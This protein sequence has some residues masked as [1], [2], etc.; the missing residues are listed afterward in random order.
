VKSVTATQPNSSS[1]CLDRR[2]K[3]DGLHRVREIRKP[4]Q[5]RKTLLKSARAPTRTMKSRLATRVAK[6]TWALESLARKTSVARSPQTM[7][8]WAVRSRGAGQ[9]NRRVSLR[10][11]GGGNNRQ[12][13]KCCPSQQSPLDCFIRSSVPPSLIRRNTSLDGRN[14]RGEGSSGEQIISIVQDQISQQFCPY[15]E[16]SV[17]VDQ[18]H[19][20]EFVH[21]VRDAR[22]RRVEKRSES[23][24]LSTASVEK[25][26]ECFLSIEP[27]NRGGGIRTPDLLRPR[28]AR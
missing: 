15:G 10:L 7:K 24:I 8:I 18:S 28:Q 21:E 13:P 14:E 5:I 1:E 25:N 4:W 11:F 3:F 26:F 22:P 17:V 9:K 16:F 19:C 12:S 27:F 20:S 2:P 6:A 23:T